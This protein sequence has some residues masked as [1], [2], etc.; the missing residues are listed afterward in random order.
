MFIKK[1]KIK[2]DVQIQKSIKEIKNWCWGKNKYLNIIS[3]PYNSSGFFS[4]IILDYVNNNKKVMYIT[5]ENEEKVEIILNIKRYSE[6]K[7][8]YFYRKNDYLDKL[9][10]VCSMDNSRYIQD[11]FDLVIYNDINGFPKYDNEN[12]I[13]II[14]KLVRRNTKVICYSID[15]IF[16]EGEN[17]LFPVDDDKIPI[18]EPRVI[19][20]RID[21]EKEL[22]FVIYDYINWFIASDRKV[23]MYTPDG[24]KVTQIYNYLFDFRKKFNV[25][26]NYFIQDKVQCSPKMISRFVEQKSGILITDCYERLCLCME[27]VDVIVFFADD[28]KFTYKQLVYFCNNTKRGDKIKGGEVLFLANENTADMDKAKE[29]TRGFNKEAWEKG[30]LNL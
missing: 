19:T 2:I 17:I 6:F 27:D 8:Y 5:D 1:D 12:I 13:N 22:P 7:E 30:L 4:E 10:T 3:V 26:L 9:L 11:D 29:I 15:P 21:L 23:I 14:N 16:V 24:A 25:N 20:T 18:C 28:K